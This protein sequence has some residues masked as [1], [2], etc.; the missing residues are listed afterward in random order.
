[1]VRSISVISLVVSIFCSELRAV[2]PP[3]FA[4]AVFLLSLLGV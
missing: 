3:S 1:M 2:V 4:V